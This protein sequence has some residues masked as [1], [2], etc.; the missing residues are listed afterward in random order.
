MQRK[1]VKNKDGSTSTERSATVNHPKLNQGLPTNVPTMFGGRQ[2]SE[3]N[4]ILKAIQS[5]GKDRETGRQLKSFMTIDEATSAA[6]QRSASLGR[7]LAKEKKR[8]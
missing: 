3:A 4:A 6:R 2:V 5:K 7:D 1:Q 8:K